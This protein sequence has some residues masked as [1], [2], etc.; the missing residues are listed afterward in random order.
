MQ[1]V[2]RND[3]CPC[4]SG[5]KYKAC[6]GLY[7]A[8]IQYPDTVERMIRSR[9]TA[10]AIG[11]VNYLW[12]TT[13]PDNEARAG[14]TEADFKRETL[15][16]CKKVDFTRLVIHETESE[17]ERG[18]AR[19]TLTAWYRVAGQPEDSFTERSEFVRVDGRLLYLTGVQVDVQAGDAPQGADD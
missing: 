11:D 10:Y 16:Y 15:H 5:R 19:G 3:P 17:D 1:K 7:H 2:G 6:C 8:G 18:I 9:F 12:R 4:G 13:H 14:K